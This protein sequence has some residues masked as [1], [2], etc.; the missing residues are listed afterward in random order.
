MIRLSF[1]YPNSGHTENGIEII[2]EDWGMDFSAARVSQENFSRMV[3]LAR[4]RCKF[5]P[6][7]ADMLEFSREIS[8]M[9]RRNRET[10][11]SL[12]EPAMTKAQMEKDRAIAEKAHALIFMDISPDE[13][14][15]LMAEFIDG[16]ELKN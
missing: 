13:K 14:S 5:F 16:L 6:S 11:L 15:R 4:R 10:V 9:D 3:I 8:E 7:L 2:A 1:H 12:P